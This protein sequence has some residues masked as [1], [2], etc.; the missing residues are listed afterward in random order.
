MGC[1]V[2]RWGTLVPVLAQVPNEGLA[3]S[4]F[5]CSLRRAACAWH[6]MF[7]TLA[8]DCCSLAGNDPA[9]VSL[10]QF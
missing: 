9:E 6:W 10:E 2:G 3:L 4:P 7:R 5:L 8:G 1:G